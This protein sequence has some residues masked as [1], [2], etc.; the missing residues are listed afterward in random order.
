[1]MIDKTIDFK[2][3]KSER[4]NKVVGKNIRIIR[5][6]KMLSQTT[7]GSRIGLCRHSISNIEKGKTE[8]SLY[9]LV[10]ICSKFNVMPNDILKPKQ[11]T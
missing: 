10:K 7:F 6:A 11:L 2:Q 9:H 5:N 1:M 3:R 8:L 4:L